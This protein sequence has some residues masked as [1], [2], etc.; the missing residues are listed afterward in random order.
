MRLIFVIIVYL[1]I[2]ILAY[3]YIPDFIHY[4]K[5]VFIIMTPFVIL[6][7]II[8]ITIS[9]VLTKTGISKFNIKG[10]FGALAFT[11]LVGY[12]TADYNDHYKID[13]EFAESSIHVKGIV[14]NKWDSGSGRSGHGL[15]IICVFRAKD[16]KMY[17][18]FI[19]ERVK[20]KYK[21]GDTLNVIY[22]ERNPEISK[23]V[24]IENDYNE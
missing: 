14:S 1:L 16:G 9:F 18:S 2:V 17:R 11:G 21:V 6:C 15:E 8:P 20:D 5:N 22:L 23:V 24:E 10:N 19:Q 12:I 3:Q 13:K 4:N 7:V